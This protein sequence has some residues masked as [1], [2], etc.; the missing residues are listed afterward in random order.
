M[1]ETN[2]GNAIKPKPTASPSAPKSEDEQKKNCD[3]IAPFV[4]VHYLTFL[5]EK[6][7]KSE[8]I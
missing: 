6:S 7:R 4:L 1:P 5:S 3:H 2:Q 8:K